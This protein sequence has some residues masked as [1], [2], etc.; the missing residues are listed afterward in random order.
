[1]GNSVYGFVGMHQLHEVL[2]LRRQG[3][4]LLPQRS[5]AAYSLLQQQ[6]VNT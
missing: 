5:P 2:H 6:Y 1:M 4:V 3:K